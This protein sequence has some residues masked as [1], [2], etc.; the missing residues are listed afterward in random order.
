MIMLGVWCA[1]RLSSGPITVHH[2]Q[3]QAT[4][5][6][7]TTRSTTTEDT[8]VYGLCQAAEVGTFINRPTKCV[9]DVAL[10]MRSNR[11]Q[12]NAG[13]TEYMWFTT[14]RRIQQLPA[15][16]ISIDGHDLLPIVS[17]RNLGVYFDS[18]LGMRRLIDV[19]TATCY[20]TLRQLRAVRRYVSQP[21]MQ[22][23]VTSLVLSR[24][25]HFNCVLFCRP[26]SSIRRL[27]SVENAAARLVFNIRR[28]DH[29]TDALVSVHWLRVAERIRF[30]MVVMA[31]RSINGLPPSYLHGFFPYQAGRPGLRSASSRRLI[32]PRTRLS[33]VGDRS[34]PVAG[35]KVWNDFSSCDLC[36]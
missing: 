2:V 35:T 12:M 27:Q 26:A 5:D 11:L 29:V 17:A 10:W 31:F 23:L 19:I 36:S 9:D 28:S 20:A 4:V 7:R 15:S 13:K 6:S 8:Q 3:R 25:D 30:K 22:S 24:L 33:M 34:F 16:A 14:P 32:M 1:A 18:H 21:V